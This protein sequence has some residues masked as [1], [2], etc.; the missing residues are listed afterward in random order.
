V[1]LA[2]NGDLDGAIVEFRTSLH[3]NPTDATIHYNL[4]LALA[5]QGEIAPARA[6]FEE[7]LR[8][9]HPTPENE[10]VIKSIQGHLNQLDKSQR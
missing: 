7:A 9:I 4:G 2:E 3:L 5:S 1:A 6:E 8:L 10:G